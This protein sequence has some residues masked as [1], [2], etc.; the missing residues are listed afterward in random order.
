[1][2]VK[3]YSDKMDTLKKTMINDLAVD[4]SLSKYALL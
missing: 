3:D 1:M 4:K 2:T